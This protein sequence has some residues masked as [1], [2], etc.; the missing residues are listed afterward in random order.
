MK[1]VVLDDDPTGSQ[2]VNGCLL[3]LSWE[4]NLLRQGL[5]N[6]SPLLFI[7]ANTRALMP[8]EAARRTREICIALGKAMQAE[9]IKPGELQIVSRGDSTLRGHGVLEPHVIS[10]ALGPFSATLHVPAFFE[11]GRTTV[12]G[13]HLLNGVPV[14]KTAFAKDRLFSYTT[15][16]LAEWLEIKSGGLITQ[17]KVKRI[18][19]AQ[20]DLAANSSSGMRTLEVWLRDLKNNENVVVD[21]ECFEQLSALGKVVRNL[22]GE[23]RFLFRCAASMLNGLTAVKSSLM[24]VN[25]LAT[26]RRRD[27]HG[28]A[29]PGMVMVGSHVPLADEQL[30]CLLTQPNCKGVELKASE[31]ARGIDA[32]FHDWL[33]TDLEKLCLD[34]M[35]EILASG[36]TPVLYSSR[37]E[38]LF[39]STKDRLNFGMHL[40]KLMARLAYALSPKLGYLIS[41]GGIT[42]HTLLQEGFGVEVVKLEGQILPGL[43]VVIPSSKRCS[44]DLPIVTFPGNLGDVESLLEAWRLME[45]C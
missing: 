43:S 7:L 29:L 41:K 19:I 31:L 13:I 9:G 25:D 38:L 6:P 39:S 30:R 21:A 20:L 16:D 36:L 33:L 12:N 3:M 11:G 4:V 40:S 22:A 14:H 32:G 18:S 34:E 17:E 42:T 23:K 5:K 28:R 27:Q 1:I 45:S 44:K 37:G 2:T 8:V 35:F 15:S 24:N 26:L 10:D